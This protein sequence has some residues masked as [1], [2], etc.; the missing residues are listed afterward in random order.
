M[1]RKTFN[2]I[3][4]STPAVEQAAICLRRQSTPAEEYLWQA[5][6][7]RKLHGLRFRRQHP[8]GRFILDFF[9]P[10]CKLVIE[11]DGGIHTQQID[12]DAIRTQEM[13]AYGYHVIRFENQQVLNDL[14][15]VLD[16]IYQAAIMCSSKE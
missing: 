10:A 15:S 5:L 4:G 8:V 13:E 2:R 9:C 1:P 14:D 16:A 7:N 12:Y 3:R 6:R 11:L